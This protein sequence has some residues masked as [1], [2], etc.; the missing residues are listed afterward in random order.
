MINVS[1]LI[2]KFTKFK[3]LSKFKMCCI[4]YINI[5]DTVKKTLKKT[6]KEEV[7][8]QFF[9]V[10]AKMFAFH[11]K[12]ST[13]YYHV[14]IQKNFKNVLKIKSLPNISNIRHKSK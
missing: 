14:L 3:R 2:D 12:S 7:S 6:I 4:I 9:I 13:D 5:F 8:F 10:C 1:Q 11:L